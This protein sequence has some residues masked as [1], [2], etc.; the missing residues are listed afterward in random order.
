MDHTTRAALV[1]LGGA[2]LTLV[3]CSQTSRNLELDVI[4][5]E[6]GVSLS[7][8]NRAKKSGQITSYSWDEKRRALEISYKQKK[9]PPRG[10]S[11]YYFAKPVPESRVLAVRTNLDRFHENRTTSFIGISEFGDVYE[12]GP[13]GTYKCFY[14]PHAKLVE[15]AYELRVRDPI[16]WKTH[17]FSSRGSLI[18]RY[19]RAKADGDHKLA[20]G[21]QRQ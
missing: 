17:K 2:L 21:D 14:N 7:A 16:F 3:A 15:S 8:L 9:K 6:H 18:D 19:R 12:N 4:H 13:P 11:I 1:I 10:F 5:L 20:K